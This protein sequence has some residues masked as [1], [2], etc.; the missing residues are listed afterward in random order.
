MALTGGPHRRAMKHPLRNYAS[1][2]AR[3]RTQEACSA[4]LIAAH[5]APWRWPESE[6]LGTNIGIGQ[7]SQGTQLVRHRLAHRIALYLNPL[8]CFIMIAMGYNHIAPDEAPE[9]S[10]LFTAAALKMIR[11][12]SIKTSL[13]SAPGN[14]F[15]SNCI[16]SG[17]SFFN[18]P[19]R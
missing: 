13:P 9:S 14:C 18:S 7:S 10:D 19:H 4:D 12:P 2:A 16:D 17:Q 3:Q 15:Q 6:P 1:D 11:L 8:I 5:D